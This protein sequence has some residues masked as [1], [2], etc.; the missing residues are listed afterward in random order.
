MHR[1]QA[2][3][4]FLLFFSPRP[5]TQRRARE[6]RRPPPFTSSFPPPNAQQRV[7][8]PVVYYHQASEYELLEQGSS[9]S[10]FSLLSLSLREQIFGEA[11]SSSSRSLSLLSRWSGASRDPVDDQH[12]ERRHQRCKVGYPGTSC[13]GA[14]SCTRER[15]GRTVVGLHSRRHLGPLRVDRVLVN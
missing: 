9:C 14:S 5:R 10:L 2:S 11:S 15:L 7:R 13:S 4:F 8:T 3:R 1:L 12:A 6:P